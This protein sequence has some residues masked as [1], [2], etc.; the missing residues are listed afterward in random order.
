M[1]RLSDLYQARKTLRKEGISKDD[2]EKQLEELEE[3]IIK[4]EILPVLTDKIEPI[5]AQ[6]ERPLVL[7]VEYT[8]NEPLSVKLSRKINIAK[9]LKNMEAKQITPTGTK[10][11]Q[12]M[13]S[14]QTTSLSPHEPTRQIINHTKGLKVTFRRWHC[15]MRENSCR[16]F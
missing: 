2:L 5:L 9:A 6:I 1:S 4:E 10:V 13:T 15:D 16:N 12:A 11:G 7:V 3:N 14:Q 8:P